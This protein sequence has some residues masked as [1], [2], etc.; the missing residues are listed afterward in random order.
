MGPSTP[1]KAPYHPRGIHRRTGRKPG[2]VT[3]GACTPKTRLVGCQGVQHVG[4]QLAA[5]YQAR[6]YSHPVPSDSK[7]CVHV[8]T[9]TAYK[10]SQQR[11]A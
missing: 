11:W 4:K 1:I 7:V 6:T 5:S 9:S 10:C 2:V 8:C 3:G